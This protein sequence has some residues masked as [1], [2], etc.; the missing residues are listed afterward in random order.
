MVEAEPSTGWQKLARRSNEFIDSCEPYRLTA[1]P[2]VLHDGRVVGG[3]DNPLLSGGLAMSVFAL[4][5]Y[6]QVSSHSLGYATR[7]LEFFESSEVEPGRL[8]RRKHWWSGLKYI[9]KDEYTGFLLGLHFL[10]KA[11]RKAERDDIVDRATRLMRRLAVRFLDNDWSETGVWAYRFPYTRLFKFHLDRTYQGKGTIPTDPETGDS[12]LD[13]L[14]GMLITLSLVNRWYQPRRLFNDLCRYIRIPYSVAVTAGV[15]P[16]FFN[17]AQLCHC[18]IMI[19][20]NQTSYRARR[21]L[22]AGFRSMFRFFSAAAPQPGSGDGCRNAYLGL[23]AHALA[24]NVNRDEDEQQVGYRMWR[25]VLDPQDRWYPDLPLC[26][27]PGHEPF[28]SLGIGE[29]FTWEHRSTRQA[30]HRLQWDWSKVQVSIGPP[31]QVGPLLDGTC[32]QTAP[33]Y[34]VEGSGLDLLFVRMLA[35]HLG[36]APAPFLQDD[37][38][39]DLLPYPGPRP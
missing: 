36:L 30:A 1:C 21:D 23:V 10:L 18:A 22:W 8:Q 17:V 9:S 5:S 29:S 7:L 2:V 38:L 34:M 27:L 24:R 37:T 31:G 12:T 25:S 20:D 32:T 11:A 6:H 14:L 35:V 3:G 19:L 33:G 16:N 13:A 26:A 15:P 28:R 39:H 4:E